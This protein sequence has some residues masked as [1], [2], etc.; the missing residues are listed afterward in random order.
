MD[1]R[2]RDRHDPLKVRNQS[3]RLRNAS[4][5]LSALSSSHPLKLRGLLGSLY[6]GPPRRLF[7]PMPRLSLP[8]MVVA[9]LSPAL[10]DHP[11]F[12]I[13]GLAFHCQARG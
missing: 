11:K 10:P 13:V 5:V 12:Y 3:T 4:L 7:S 9:V 2:G 8:D 1:G 6:R